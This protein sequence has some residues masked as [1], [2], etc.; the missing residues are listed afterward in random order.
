M[1]AVLPTADP[2]GDAAF[3]RARA[4]A[5]EAECARLTAENVTLAASA[6][7]MKALADS[8]GDALEK[9]E[10]RVA[11]L[12]GLLF[13]PSSEKNPQGKKSTARDDDADEPGGTGCDSDSDSDGIDTGSGSENS[14]GSGSDSD[15]SGSS[16]GDGA[17][18]GDGGAKRRRGQQKGSK[19]HG[20][21]R[22]E[23]LDTEEHVH[24]LPEDQKRCP[25]CGG[26]YEPLGEDVSEQVTWEVSVRRVVHRRRK[27]AR[28]CRCAAAPAVVTAP[29]P[30]KL[31]A[32][33][34]FDT[35]FCV[36]LL[37][38]KYA[39]GLPANRVIAML[40]MQGLEVAPG[41][42]AG[43]SRRLGELLAP[44]AEAITERNAASSQLHADETSWRVFGEKADN[45]GSRWWLWVF[46]AP[47][48]V[49]YTIAPS[50]SR[51]VLVEH[52]G[53]TEAEE[54]GED[55]TT[56]KVWRLPDGRGDVI[57]ISDFYAVYQ[58]FSGIDGVQA[59]WCWA[60]LRRKIIDAWQA[61]RKDLAAWAGAWL[62]RIGRLYAAHDLLGRCPEGDPLHGW[63]EQRF[64]LALG[65]ISY[66]RRLQ[67]NCA[68]YLHPA[69]RKAVEALN[70]EW[71]GL[72]AHRDF[73]GLP[74]DNNTAERAIRGPVV[75]RKNFY[76]SGA[77]WAAKLAASAWTVLATAR[78]HG[79]SPAAWLTAYLGACAA[80][81]GKAPTGAAQEALLPWNLTPPGPAP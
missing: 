59:L 13:G 73:P 81:G 3:W 60:H 55:G 69:A 25:R 35:Q 44:V 67:M 33:G 76:G 46:T 72:A 49:V 78:L 9:S 22:H 19:G 28:S 74:L 75:G 8:L 38:A 29:G 31:I 11:Q 30:G 23:H 45:G 36:N 80:N 21:R 14:R 12:S 42:L 63:A 40:A 54:A 26:Q 53:L 16:P 50:R 77:R 66:F 32:R 70:R 39:L 51:T 15:G 65:E 27:Y 5:L 47:D 79:H 56:R 57:L 43:V 71:D 52:F 58:W 37:V 7:A 18:G 6:E 62:A 10:E 20:R 2:A 4:E 48:T 17:A 1:L 24:D 34:K 68:Q 61:H 41:T 64:A